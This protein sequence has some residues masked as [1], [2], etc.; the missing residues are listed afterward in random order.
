MDLAIL[1]AGAAKG[2]VRAL[3]PALVAQ[4]G[5]GV[6]GSFGAVGAMKEKLL[7]GEPCDLIVLSARMIDELAAAGRVDPATAA[8]LGR[9]GTGVAVRSG[10]PLPDI[11]DGAALART[12]RAASGI[13]LPDPA[14]ATA[15]IHFVEVLKRLGVYAEVEPRLRPYP[16][17]ATAMGELAREAQPGRVGC[18]QITEIKYTPGVT[19]VGPLP[20]G[21][22]LETVYSVAVCTRAAQP[23]FAQLFADLLAGPGSAG[24]REAGGFEA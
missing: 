24:L 7:A 5:I 17:G 23:E 19:L 12:L 1:C 11:A 10:A 9:V 18:T 14:R 13:L 4:T 2:L 6:R 20:A 16:N 21:Y 8:S 22:A 3:E 15:G